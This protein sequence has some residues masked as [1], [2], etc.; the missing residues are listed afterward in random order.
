MQLS[1]KRDRRSSLTAAMTGANKALFYV[2]SRQSKR[3]FLINTGAEVSVLPATRFDR[4]KN[5]PHK[6]YWRLT[7]ARLPL[8]TRER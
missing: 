2:W 8:S 5:S 4:Q 6:Y 1:G 3:N 7:A